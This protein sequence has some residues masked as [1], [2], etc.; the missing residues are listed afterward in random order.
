[1][2]NDRSNVGGGQAGQAAAAL[3]N[4]SDLDA[5]IR[6][7]VDI[8]IG[9]RDVG[10]PALVGVDTNHHVTEGGQGAGVQLHRDA[11]D[12]HGDDGSAAATQG[13]AICDPDRRGTTSA[14]RTGGDGKGDL[15]VTL[16]ADVADVGQHGTKQRGGE[17]GLPVTHPGAE[18]GNGTSRRPANRRGSRGGKK[19]RGA[20]GGYKLHSVEPGPTAQDFHSATVAGHDHRRGSHWATVYQV[21]L[22]GPANVPMAQLVSLCHRVDCWEGH[23]TCHMEVEMEHPFG[24]LVTVFT[25]WFMERSTQTYHRLCQSGEHPLCRRA[26][27]LLLVTAKE[28]WQMLLKVETASLADY[29]PPVVVMEGFPSQ[30]A[31]STYRRGKSSPPSVWWESLG[32][33]SRC[34]SS[35]IQGGLGQVHHPAQ[36]QTRKMPESRSNA[37][38]QKSTNRG[39]SH[40]KKCERRKAALK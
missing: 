22:G 13:G 32:G 26:E 1:M 17:S 28:E 30:S 7:L 21:P 5:A 36:D 40:S 33:K 23:R 39:G 35:S 31:D 2:S 9:R 6:G 27:E 24:M 10:G 38:L 20:V 18:S 25:D 12:A 16:G 4:M 29:P 14:R 15:G 3:F 8:S 37:P 34:Q 19:K 11:T